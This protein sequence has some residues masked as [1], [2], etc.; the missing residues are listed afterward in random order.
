MKI[1]LNQLKRQIILS[2]LVF[3]AFKDTIT[4]P[5][6]KRIVRDAYKALLQELALDAR[7]HNEIAKTL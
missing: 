4:A 6:T 2:A 5:A 1:E 3:P 7:L